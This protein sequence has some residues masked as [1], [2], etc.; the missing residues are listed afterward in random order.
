[1]PSTPRVFTFKSKGT[2]HANKNLHNCLCNLLVRMFT[3]SWDWTDAR[4]SS[5][6]YTLQRSL[7]LLT[8]PT[9]SS[10]LCGGNKKYIF[11]LDRREVSRTRTDVSKQF[12]SQLSDLKKKKKRHPTLQPDQSPIDH[13]PFPRLKGMP[14]LA[15]CKAR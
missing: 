7:L 9:L 6:T 10:I 3:T 4:V 5:T 2:I 15:T 13:H 8:F 14:I 12:P 1:M 11:D